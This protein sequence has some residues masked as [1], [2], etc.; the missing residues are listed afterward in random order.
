[1][2]VQMR[3]P[4]SI[5]ANPTGQESTTRKIER[6]SRPDFELSVGVLSSPSSDGSQL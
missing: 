4:R 2:V 1:M 6:N 3:I 5:D